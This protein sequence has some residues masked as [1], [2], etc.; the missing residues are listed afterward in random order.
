MKLSIIVPMLNE[1]PVLPDLLAHLLPLWRGGVE[2]VLADGGSDDGSAAIAACAGFSVVRAERGR[3]RA[4]HLGA[5][6]EPRLRG[7]VW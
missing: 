6:P 2:V 5:H 3:A 7:R 1:A 4:D